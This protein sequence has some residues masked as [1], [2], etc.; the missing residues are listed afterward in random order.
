MMRKVLLFVVVLCATFS[1]AQTGSA[2]KL[3]TSMSN[4][5]GCF[6]FEYD[7]NGVMTAAYY[8][9]EPPVFLDANAEDVM[10]RYAYTDYVDC[11]YYEPSHLQM[12][13][14]GAVFTFEGDY[15]AESDGLSFSTLDMGIHRSFFY[16]GEGNMTRIVFRL[17]DTLNVRI[18]W[19]SGNVRSVNLDMNGRDG[20]SISF[21][22]TDTLAQGGYASFGSPLLLLLTYYSVIPWNIVKE[23]FFGNTCRHLVS[24]IETSIDDEF[25][26][27]HDCIWN[28]NDYIP[29]MAFT[30]E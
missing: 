19:D 10:W 26:V 17:V 24:R 2:Q 12:P 20:G 9:G 14:Q 4:E 7:D 27:G 8:K 1:H 28:S 30:R 13:E 6:S 5:K 29:F 21:A 15:I 25:V 23:G 11:Q 16:D 18:Q 3:L 22:Y